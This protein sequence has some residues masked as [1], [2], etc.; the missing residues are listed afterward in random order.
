MFF[1]DIVSPCGLEDLQRISFSVL[2]TDSG[3]ATAATKKGESRIAMRVAVGVF[4]FVNMFRGLG[5][6][7]HV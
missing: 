7:R 5:D 2:S 1:G 4:I 6:K 3:I